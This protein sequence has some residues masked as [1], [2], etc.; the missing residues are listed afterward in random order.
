MKSIKSPSQLYPETDFYLVAEAVRHIDGNSMADGIVIATG[1][2][3]IVGGIKGCL[4][5]PVGKST[6]V[7][8]VHR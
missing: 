3:W 6:R 5:N 1:G 8:Q 7:G 4:T 2:I